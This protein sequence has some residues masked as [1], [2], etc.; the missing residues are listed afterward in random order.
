MDARGLKE[1]NLNKG[2]Y[3][4]IYFKEAQFRCFLVSG[5]TDNSVALNKYGIVDQILSST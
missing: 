5:S 1:W 2:Q 4:L 3:C